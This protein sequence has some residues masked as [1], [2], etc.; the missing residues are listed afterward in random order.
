MAPEAGVL[1]IGVR[2]AGYCVSC[3]YVVYLHLKKERFMATIAIQKKRKNIDLPVE[4]LQ[5]LSIMAAMQGKNLKA[6]IE[7]LLIAKADT[8]QIEF[9]NPSPSGDA[10]FAAP[11]NLAEVEKRAKAYREGKGRMAV[12]LRSAED[13]TNFI[14]NI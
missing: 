2:V 7:S 3:V 10:Y 11:E 13:I 6:F 14:N 9:S 1:K 4:T 8:L 12:T 5:K